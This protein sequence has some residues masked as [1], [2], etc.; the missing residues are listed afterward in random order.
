MIKKRKR[1]DFAQFIRYLIL[2][3]LTAFEIFPLLL[4]IFNSFRPDSEVK[5]SPIGLPHIGFFDNYVDTWRMGQ[6]GRAYLNTFFIMF[7]VIIIV[8]LFDGLAAYALARLNMKYKGVISGYFFVAMSLPSFLYIITVYSKM[9]QLGLVDTPWS[10]IIVY[11][12]NQIPFTLILMR[13]FMTGIPRELEE[14]ARIDGCDDMQAFWKITLPIS[15]PIFLTSALLAA[16]TVWNEYLWS[17]TFLPTEIN[18][19]VATKYVVFTGQ[20]SSNMARIYTASVISIVPI[21]VLYILFS[22]RFI[23]GLT[24]GAVKS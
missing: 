3:I 10:L 2:S 23:E 4:V 6:Y 15:K 8:L 19:T 5:A 20:Y 7:F 16:C 21:C 12:A 14:A 24:S 22:R 9:R 17:N 11:S 1:F 13:T 18:K